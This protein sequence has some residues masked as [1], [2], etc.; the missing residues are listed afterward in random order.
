MTAR[1]QGGVRRCHK[2]VCPTTAVVSMAYHYADQT[3]YLGPLSDAP[4]PHM[5]DLCASHA[6]AMKFPRGWQV[7]RVVAEPTIEE[8]TAETVAD[9][10]DDLVAEVADAVR[11]RLTQTLTVETE[12][13]DAA[14]GP[15]DVP[16]PRRR[17]RR[18][19]RH[20]FLVR[21]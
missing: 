16:V 18:R 11:A 5:H 15:E 12:E 9:V 19:A 8:V 20:L 3:A 14:D 7:I 6:N 17:P 13:A 4:D 1:G 2:T 21:E 10:V